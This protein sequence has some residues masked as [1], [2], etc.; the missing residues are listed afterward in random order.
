MNFLKKKW[1]LL[2]LG[3]IVATSLFLATLSVS[4]DSPT[5]DET[6]HIAAGYVKLH[7]GYLNF[8]IE[9]P[10]LINALSAL[11]LIISHIK[12]DTSIAKSGSSHWAVGNQFL[13]GSGYNPE[14]LLFL[15]RIPTLILFGLLI[16]A[17]YF[18]TNRISRSKAASLIGATLTA[19]CPNLIANGRLATVDMGVTFFLFLS[20]GT[21]LLFIQKPTK[22]KLLALGIFIGLALA[23]K[24]SALIIFP[25]TLFA[26]ILFVSFTK[27]SKKES[28]LYYSGYKIA[29]IIS[30]VVLFG[31]YF[32]ML[33]G[34]YLREFYGGGI[35]E[36]FRASFYEYARQIKA[37]YYWS[38]QPYNKPEFLLGHFSFTGWWYYYPVAFFF[39]TPI[40]ILILFFGS[41]V[42]LFCKIKEGLQK[43]RTNNL[44]LLTI[45]SL[46]FIGSFFVVSAFSK[47]DIGLR[48]ILPIYPVLYLF[49]G[50]MFSQF[51]AEIKKNKIYSILTYLLVLLTVVV[52]LRTFPSYLAYFN[53]FAGRPVNYDKILIDSNLDW[54]QDLRR[55]N[56]WM[57]NNDVE[58]IH[59]DYFG[60]GGTDYYLG[61]KYISTQSMGPIENGYYAISRQNFRTSSFY[62]GK[63]QTWE[64]ATKDM[65]LVTIIG[66]SIYV[67]QKQ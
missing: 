20:V 49:I 60:G 37:I 51:E 36:R 56:T 10:P 47:L 27:Q 19:F 8:F 42:G 39:K 4:H 64:D 1:A 33:R 17:V 21:F 54:G 12:F 62:T 23:S 46:I 31:I 57:N 16:I 35:L 66:N 25:Y 28:S 3:L 9:Q 40:S 14:R 30:F 5:D 44:L 52:S 34:P 18:F 6:A 24:V 48:Y 59:L 67:F 26:L 63:I 41:L 65:K 13:F 11:P 43:I 7:D 38:S 45:L 61:N 53:E 29:I 50:L 2:L 22:K 58:K 55:L 15:A 32:L